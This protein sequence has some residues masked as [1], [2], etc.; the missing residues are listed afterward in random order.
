MLLQLQKGVL[1]GPVN[2]RRY[3]K[4]LGI[5]L[6]P[7]RY[8]LCSFNCVYCHY[9][10]TKKCTTDMRRYEKDLPALESVVVAVEQAVKSSVEFDL[11]TFSGNG[12]PTLYP[13]FSELVEAVAWHR[14][15]FRPEAKLAL[16]SNATGL[17]KDSVRESISK[18]DLPIL[19]LDAGSAEKFKA[20][21]RPARKVDYAEVVENLEELPDI[22]LQTVLVDG[23]PSNITDAELADYCLAAKRIKPREI[24]V[25][26][27]DRPVPNVRI[28]LV[29]PERLVQL[30]MLIEQE[31]GVSTRAFYSHQATA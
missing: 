19:K 27:I 18:F 25:Y 7:S 26:S 29:P 30:A 3:G 15:R 14:D 17:V 6:S 31:T 1:Y 10:W 4:S 11:I 9:G 20:I 24:H 16:L 22:Y 28:T 8:K 13:A 5:N 23:V 2:S 12:E 21:N